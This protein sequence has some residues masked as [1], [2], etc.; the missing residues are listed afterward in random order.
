MGEGDC[1]P[2]GTW[3][4]PTVGASAATLRS[5]GGEAVKAGPIAR[6]PTAPISTPHAR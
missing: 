3:N 4:A 6:R 1:S 2:S 5:T